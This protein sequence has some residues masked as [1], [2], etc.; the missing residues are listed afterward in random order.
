MNTRHFS[1]LAAALVLAAS[2]PAQ[3]P[4]APAPPRPAPSLVPANFNPIT[5]SL[6]FMWDVNQYGGISQGTNCFSEAFSLRINNSQFSGQNGMMTPDGSEF[7]QNA[8]VS[9]IDVTR[10]ARVD[11]KAGYCRFIDTLRNGGAAVQTLNV[12]I[13]IQF[14]NRMQSVLTDSSAA[15]NPGQLGPKDCGVVCV[16][17]TNTGRQVP[18][19]LWMLASPAGKVRPTLGNQQNYRMTASYPVTLAPGATVTLVHAAAQ[20][21]LTGGMDAK[22]LAK[23]FAPLK[24]PRLV[25]DIPAKERKAFAN[26]TAS[27]MPGAD[28]A[29]LASLLEKL[30]VTRGATDVLA[31]GADTRL[32]GTASCAALEIETR[33]GKAQIPFE[34]V[35]AVVG[36]AHGSRV[37]LRDGQV[38]SGTL[39]APGLKFTLSTGTTMELNVSALDRLV[40]RATPQ[41]AAASAWGFVETVEGDRVAVKPDRSLRLRAN[42]PWGVR[43]IV[44]DDLIGCGVSEE[45]PL[46][47][48]VTL[49]DGSRFIALL[50]GDTLAF[51]T[52]LFGRKEFATAA[53]RRIAIVQPKSTDDSDE[54]T[55][56]RPRLAILGGQTL[57]G[58]ID[59]AELHFHSPAGIIP[60][61]PNLIRTLHN[62]SADGS[63]ESPVFS[64]ELWG[65]GAVSGSL[66]ETL[67]PVRSGGAILHVPVREVTDAFVP[68]PIVP[69]G[70][71]DKIAGLVRDLGDPGWEKREAAS[72]ELGELGAMARA[73][74]EETLK[75]TSDAEVRRRAQALLDAI[76]G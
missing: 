70:L 10:R 27:G 46:Q 64:A 40:L 51:D 28:G 18:S 24:S 38:L 36:G 62:T 41:D 17:P 54:V 31:I 19:V 3:S 65:G 53:I 5:D 32:R 7:F 4:Q 56:E 1:A 34:R 69:E 49:K 72:R 68:S 16:S 58:Q 75:Q 57:G 50:D 9:G 76:Q 11:A 66:R 8:K 42:T 63:E 26:F 12:V 33:L 2:L 52:V 14:N 48:S 35:A 74:L 60:V 43:E 67:L 21:N 25:A 44:P 20:R 22:T 29:A 13:Q 73:Q 55:P 47:F 6:G 23:L 15:A 37:L 59:L 71:R 39:T 30:G 45:S 61:A